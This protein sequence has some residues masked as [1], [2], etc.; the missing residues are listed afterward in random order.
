MISSKVMGIKSGRLTNGWISQGQGP[1]QR[2]GLLPTIVKR[3]VLYIPRSLI[4][5][6]SLKRY[7]TMPHISKHQLSCFRDVAREVHYGEQACYESPTW[8]REQGDQ[9]EGLE[10][11]NEELWGLGTGHWAGPIGQRVGSSLSQNV[12]KSQ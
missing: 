3:Q 5:F 12:T 2:E 4:F 11:R 7:I 8:K 6:W 1:Y 9:V 10:V